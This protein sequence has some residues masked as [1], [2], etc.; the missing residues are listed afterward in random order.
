[1][2][3]F[4]IAFEDKGGKAGTTVTALTGG[5]AVTFDKAIPT[6]T[7][8]MTSNNTN[9][10]YAKV[11]DVVTLTIV[12]NEDTQNVVG[13]I[14]GQAMATVAGIDDKHW[15]TTYTMQAGDTDGLLEFTLDF[16]DLAGNPATQIVA[17]TSGTAVTFD[18]V[19]PT[20]SSAVRNND[21]Q[22]E[23]TLSELAIASTITKANAGGFT[24]T[25]TGGVATYAVSA[26][27]PGATNDKIVLTVAS[28]TVSGNEGVTV[29]YTAGG[30]GTVADLASNAL[31][32]NAV[33]VVVAAW[34]TEAP[35]MI[36]AERM[37]N[38]TLKV[39]LSENANDAT[40]TKANAGGFTVTELGAPLTTYA[41]SAIAKSGSNSNMIELTVADVSASAAVGLTVTYT[42]GGNGTVADPAGNLMATDGTGENIASWA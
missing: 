32:T 23:V 15:T 30:N 35:T 17:V 3:T 16:D 34:E 13:N 8:T 42:Q 2:V 40:I 7:V 18:E 28:M 11:G 10:A 31:A 22:L 27:A 38:T 26:I 36:S 21:T 12:T 4:S 19:V 41:V 33:G 9:P 24:V 37:A 5:S 25:E 14:D 29:T 1:V 39:T 6:A 20:L